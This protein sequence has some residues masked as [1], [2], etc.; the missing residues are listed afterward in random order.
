MHEC[1]CVCVCVCVS[2]CTCVYVCVCAC[3]CVCVHV[4]LTEMG[5]GRYYGGNRG[6][7]EA[8]IQDPGAYAGNTDHTCTVWSPC[9]SGLRCLA[10]FSGA[11]DSVGMVVHVL[12]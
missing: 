3:I 11:T 8:V 5:G 2:I 12:R 10:L 6:R 4:C 7:P 1:V 9:L